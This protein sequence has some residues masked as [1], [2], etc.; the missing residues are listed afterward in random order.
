VPLP[1][2]EAFATEVPLIGRLD[3]KRVKTASQD[4]L[5]ANPELLDAIAAQASG[6]EA[7]TA[8]GGGGSSKGGKRRKN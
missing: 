6:A 2:Q 5:A 7:N 4:M 3:P 8:G 1:L